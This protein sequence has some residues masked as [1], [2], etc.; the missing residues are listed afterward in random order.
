[1]REDTQQIKNNNNIMIF[2]G[3]YIKNSKDNNSYITYER[4][5]DASYRKYMN[6]ETG[7]LVTIEKQNI[8]N[9]ETT[10][11]TLYLPIY[12]YSEDEYYKSYFKLQNWY[13]EQLN[14][15]IQSDIISNLKQKYERNYK[16]I[17]PIYRQ[18]DAIN[19]LPIDQ[20]IKMHPENGFIE[21]YCLSNEEKMVAKLYR[22][23]L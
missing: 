8:L 14:Y 7:E 3:S 19:D 10:N 22:K 1:M 13:K 11:I 21:N 20:Y 5:P 12:E 18:I 9:Y 23:T 15:H 6:L 17:Y 4:N 16:K 2:M